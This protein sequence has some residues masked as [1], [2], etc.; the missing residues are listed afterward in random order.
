MRQSVLSTKL[1]TA[2]T[3]YVPM[4]DIVNLSQTSS[5][6]RRVCQPVIQS[7]QQELSLKYTAFNAVGASKNG[8]RFV[9]HTLLS[10]VLENRLSADS[11]Y[12]IECDELCIDIAGESDRGAAFNPSM[13]VAHSLLRRALLR[14]SWIS[15][16][17][18]DELVS[19]MSHGNE[20]AVLSF[21]VPLLG[22]LRHIRLP[23]LS[24]IHI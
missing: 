2:I 8:E 3:A 21:L 18:V 22:N 16:A 11:V 23:I 12:S 13:F 4:R 1:W 6:L 17:S 5:S 9:F 7:R 20:D 14:A 15:P 19:E 10:H 24:L